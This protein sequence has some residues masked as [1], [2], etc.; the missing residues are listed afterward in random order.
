MSTLTQIISP[1]ST[2]STSYGPSESSQADNISIGVSPTPTTALRLTTTTSTITVVSSQGGYPSSKF[3]S[4][5]AQNASSLMSDSITF[6]C[7][8]QWLLFRRETR[9]VKSKTASCCTM[10]SNNLGSIC[11]LMSGKPLSKKF[12]KNHALSRYKHYFL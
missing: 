9:M 5:P 12:T 6:F 10:L 3:S 2:E 4:F 11:H 8:S 7:K 1:S